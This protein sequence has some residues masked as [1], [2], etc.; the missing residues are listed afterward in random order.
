M[1]EYRSTGTRDE[2]E[3]LVREKAAKRE[4]EAKRDEMQRLQASSSSVEA[5]KR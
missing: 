5:E 4:A 3:R 1:P 2:M